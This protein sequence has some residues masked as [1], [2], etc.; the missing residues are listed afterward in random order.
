MNKDISTN[1]SFVL[2][3]TIFISFTMLF[4][5]TYS[6]LRIVALL[7]LV[8]Y[9]IIFQRYIFIPKIL[10]QVLVFYFGANVISFVWGLLRGAEGV[11]AVAKPYLLWPF[12]FTIFSCV[13]ISHSRIRYVIKL[14]LVVEALICIIDIW[15]CF[16]ELGILPGY[17]AFLLNLKMGF[18]FAKDWVPMRFSTNHVCTHIFMF[19]FTFALLI[20]N[21]IYQK[22]NLKLI[23]LFFL[24][25]IAVILSGR[26]ALWVI[27]LISI[28][29]VYLVEK[30]TGRIKSSDTRVSSIKKRNRKIILAIIVLIG[31]TFIVTKY[32]DKIMT[33][34]N[35]ISVKFVNSFT[36]NSTEDSTRRVQ[37]YYLLKGWSDNLLLGN[38][39]GSYCTEYIRDPVSPWDYE[40]TFHYVLFQG[41]LLGILS[42]V[43]LYGTIIIILWK[44]FIKRRL[45]YAETIPFIF[46]MFAIIVTSITEPY[47]L[48]SGTM[49]MVFIPLGI[50]SYSY[51]TVE[52]E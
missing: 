3:I 43:L 30:R 38:G 39:M 17:P 18:S 5:S 28:I 49:W 25:V 36:Y 52:I 20:D 37:S 41:G 10:F 32:S 23:S 40:M 46:G 13:F 15:Y 48:K 8:L 24:E 6:L 45:D 35:A 14:L 26:I 33:M 51:K 34:A 21:L 9:V 22:A 29:G 12:L 31:V 44:A 4:P 19:P 11:L 7:L 47:L 27:S 16:S 1:K 42:F 50:A 2:L